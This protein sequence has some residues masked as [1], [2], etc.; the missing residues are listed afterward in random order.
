[1]EAYLFGWKQPQHIQDIMKDTLLLDNRN[2]PHHKC[3]RFTDKMARKNLAGSKGGQC[4]TEEVLNVVHKLL[5]K[6]L[7]TECERQERLGD[8]GTV[9]HDTR[10]I[11]NTKHGLKNIFEAAIQV[12][13][14]IAGQLGHEIQDGFKPQAARN[15]QEADYNID[16]FILVQ[17]QDT[18]A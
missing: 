14:Q 12:L 6:K 15:G 10:G 4:I 2:F 9:H 8:C 16:Y 18:E 13:P 5:P 1:M 3:Q 17:Y 7:E 11:D